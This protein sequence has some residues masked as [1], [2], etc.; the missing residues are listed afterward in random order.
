MIRRDPQH[1]QEI[2]FTVRDTAARLGDAQRVD[3]G[4]PYWKW[5]W[6]AGNRFP[7]Q[8]LVPI[9]LAPGQLADFLQRIE[10]ADFLVF[11]KREPALKKHG[12][13]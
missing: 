2:A 6:R 9:Q 7:F 12:V 3:G 1:S 13:V 5:N 10:D 8:P 11:F 4:D